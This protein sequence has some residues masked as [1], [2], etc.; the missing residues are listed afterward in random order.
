MAFYLIDYE[1]IKRVSG[2][3]TLTE[4]DTVVFFYSQNANSMT[5]DLHFEL[6]KSLAAKA[7]F[8]LQC[9]SKN[10][11]DF[12]LSSYVG[13]LVASH[14]NEKI[15]IISNDKGFECIVAFWKEQGHNVELVTNICVNAKDESASA[16][17]VCAEPESSKVS[18]SV[19]DLL[20]QHAKKLNLSNEQCSKIVEIVNSSKTKQAINNNLMKLF[21][22]SGKVGKITKVIKPVLKNKN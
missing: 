15:C 21:R 2:F 3:N 20:K 19:F 11:L 5:F 16:K 4:K 14:P 7:Y 8:K 10:A 22:D 6:D 17:V 9:G 12:H 18:D 1:N 13:Y